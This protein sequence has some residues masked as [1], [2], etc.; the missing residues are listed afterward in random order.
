MRLSAKEKRLLRSF[1]KDNPCTTREIYDQFVTARWDPSRLTGL[2]GKSFAKAYSKM[3]TPSD[4]NQ[5]MFRDNVLV[6]LVA[7]GVI[8]TK[9]INVSVPIFFV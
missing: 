8:K 3:N 9:R 6:P 5:R 4:Y 2:E 1:L 7:E